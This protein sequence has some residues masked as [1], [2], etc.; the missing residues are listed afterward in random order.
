M[1]TRDLKTNQTRANK[2]AILRESEGIRE[3]ARNYAAALDRIRDDLAKLYERYAENG[4][5]TNA[6]M[7]KYNRLRSL[8][9][10]ITTTIRP[11]A[12]K[13]EKL[14]EKLTEVSYEESFYRHAWSL[15]QN[16]GVSLRWGLL[17]PDQVRAVV[18]NPLRHLA[19]RDLSRATLTRVRRAIS[20]GLIR[21]VTLRSMMQ[22]VREAMNVTANDAMR[23]V[24][25]EAHRARELGNWDATKRAAEQGIELVKVWDAALDN[26]TRSN[27]GAMDG[28]RRT[29]VTGDDGTKLEKPFQSPSGA[30]TT[31]PGGF[32]VAREDINC[33]CT[34]NDEVEGFPPKV[35]RIRD[36]GI[37]PYQTFPEWAQ[38][39]GVRG[40]RYGE[41]YNFV[42]A[43]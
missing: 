35:R 28:Q 8:E 21:G 10:Q 37:Q 34:A 13:N 23:I 32:G 3:I 29:V 5:L 16:I 6:E 14:I 11:V 17:S 26:R 1:P 18:E 9:R 38:S 24:R 42:K 40:S 31:R 27:H 43:A 41:K 33:R 19:K 20:Q 15:D 7:S 12:L 4:R 22:E 25:T 36:E 2:L 30:T 39:R